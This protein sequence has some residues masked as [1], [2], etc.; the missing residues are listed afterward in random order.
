MLICHSVTFIFILQ[1]VEINTNFIKSSFIKF[2]FSK[3]L[4]RSFFPKII[5]I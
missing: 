2:I 1:E 4:E 3:Q 5:S